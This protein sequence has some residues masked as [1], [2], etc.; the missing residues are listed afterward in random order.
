MLE[1]AFEL[2]DLRHSVEFCGP[3]L[4]LAIEISNFGIFWARGGG[5]CVPGGI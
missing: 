4:Q 5:H 2:S 1:L 3:F